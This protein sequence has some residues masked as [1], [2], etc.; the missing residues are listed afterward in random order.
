MT[1]ITGWTAELLDD[2]TAGDQDDWWLL[3]TGWTAGWLEGMIDS[4]ESPLTEDKVLFK[5]QMVGRELGF[6][7]KEIV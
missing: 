7:G 4:L 1:G 6:G 2:L 5:E 3:I